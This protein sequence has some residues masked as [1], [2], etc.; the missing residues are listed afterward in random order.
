MDDIGTGTGPPNKTSHMGYIEQ[1]EH[2]QF[3]TKRSVD[4]PHLHIAPRQ[5]QIQTHEDDMILT[6]DDN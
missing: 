3:T 4:L 5:L 2:N 6:Q 1:F